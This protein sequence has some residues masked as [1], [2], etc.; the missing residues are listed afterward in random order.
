[1]NR[2]KQIAFIGV[3]VA[4]II[5]FQTLLSSINGL[6][7]TTLLITTAALLLPLSTSLTIVVVYCLIQGIL[8]GFGDW[9]VVYIIYWTL[10][11]LVSYFL[12]SFL[13]KHLILNSILNGVYGFLLGI[14][15]FFKTLILVYNC[16]DYLV[17]RL[18]S[19]QSGNEVLCYIQ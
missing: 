9:L 17:V 4:I 7:L 12:R 11:D 2:V 8:Y 13:R 3:Y 10:I 14:F 19:L 5:A 18:L 6:E 16:S 15:F 1:M